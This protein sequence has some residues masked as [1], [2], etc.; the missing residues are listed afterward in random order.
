MFRALFR[1]LLLAGGL[2]VASLALSAC[3]DVRG[4][5]EAFGKR[6]RAYLLEHPEVLEEAIVRLDQKRAEAG[7]ATQ[8]KALATN[9]AALE[10]DRRDPVLGNPN[11]AVTVVEFFDYRCG[12][13]KSIAP[14][15]LAMLDSEKDVRFVFKEL[16]I[17]PDA[18]GRIGVSE[19][20][21]RLA[22]AAHAKGRY[23]EV[24]RDL[25]AQ[26]ALDDA[27][28]QRVARNLGLDPVA[29]ARAGATPAAADHLSD[30]QE[31]A[32]ALG[33]QGTPAFVI[34]DQ[35]VPSADPD[36]LRAAIAAARQKAAPKAA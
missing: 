5:D 6:V 21:A 3:S 12:Y 34:G 10:R 11:G 2:A 33:I 35:V 19:R 32:R 23:R 15:V 24:H 20:A 22:L 8:V 26:K 27:G 14:Q 4:K 25:M 13:C 28:I 18:N 29:L 17:L 1:A 30:N 16:P 7:V 9:R 31:L 36:A